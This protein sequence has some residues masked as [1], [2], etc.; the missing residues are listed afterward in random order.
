MVRQ[1]ARIGFSVC[2]QLTQYCNKKFANLHRDTSNCS[3]LQSLARSAASHPRVFKVFHAVA[4]C[5]GL[6]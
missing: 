3:C 4:Y 2:L 6:S 5:M 1:A